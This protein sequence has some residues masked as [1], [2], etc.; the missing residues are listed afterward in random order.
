[1]APP[2]RNFSPADLQLHRRIREE[3]SLALGAGANQEML[4]A[5]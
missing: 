1:V 5:Y 4:A 2:T 3:Q